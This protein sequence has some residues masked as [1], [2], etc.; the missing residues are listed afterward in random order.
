[1][2]L[3]I[4]SGLTRSLEE[5]EED[6][7]EDEEETEILDGKSDK[8]TAPLNPHSALALARRR[9]RRSDKGFEGRID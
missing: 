1:M 9:R 8:G 4:A 6:K 7:D 3:A 2:Q 5:G